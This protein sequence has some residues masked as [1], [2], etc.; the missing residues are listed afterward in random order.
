MRDPSLRT[1]GLPAAEA[2]L[3][4][5]RV[6]R[7]AGLVVEADGDGAHANEVALGISDD[8]GLT[9]FVGVSWR[10]VVHR[11]LP[12]GGE[13]LLVGVLVS[14]PSF[15]AGLVATKHFLLADDLLDFCLGDPE[16]LCHGRWRDVAVGGDEFLDCT[17][18]ISHRL[19]A[20]LAGTFSDAS[21]HRGVVGGVPQ[22]RVNDLPDPGDRHVELLGERVSRL[23]VEDARH[24]LLVARVQLDVSHGSFYVSTPVRVHYH[25]LG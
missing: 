7:F 3:E 6:G 24:D 10:R 4:G 13:A 12:K 2:E 1:C 18:C 25:C 21:L 16:E 11:D 23:P 8:E 17:W 14:R 19:L 15:K 5:A 20:S 22:Y 9:F